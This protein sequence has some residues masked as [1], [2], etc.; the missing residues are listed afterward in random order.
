VR[1]P[2]NP[3]W[4]GHG[5]R[6]VQRIGGFRT[7]PGHKNRAFRTLVESANKF[8][9]LL[10]YLARPKRF[11]LLTPR[12]VVWCSIQLS[13]GRGSMQCA[14]EMPDHSVREGL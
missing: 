9:Y 2:P 7:L 8:L 1:Y 6:G 14:R 3:P 13:Y 11:E 5:S 12:F 4:E 10:V